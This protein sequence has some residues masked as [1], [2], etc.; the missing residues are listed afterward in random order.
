M[1]KKTLI[2]YFALLLLLCFGVYFSLSLTNN[3][4]YSKVEHALLSSKK[5]KNELE[6][7]L[8][9]FKDD[10]EK[11][12]AAEFLISNMISHYSIGDIKFI[13]NN[14]EEA[15]ELLNITAR[16][17]FFA[18][19]NNVKVKKEIW[20]RNRKAKKEID[21]LINGIRIINNGF[22]AKDI[23]SLSSDFLIEH[24][25]N[26]YKKWKTSKL[27]DKN[28]F[29]EF[30][31]T[32]LP[33]RYANEQLNT[34][35]NYPENICN[36]LL[37]DIIPKDTKEI[38]NTL[39][40]Y[41]LR[42]ERLTS[43]I[44]Q[45]DK[46]GFYNILNWWDLY[47]D[48]QI[49]LAAQILNEIGVP[50]YLDYTP[51]WLNRTLGHSWCVSK[52]S[53]G[54]YRP[55]S[56]FYQ[57]IDS[58]ENKGVYNKNYFKRT[59]K[60]YRKTYE[61]Q[62]QSAIALKKENEVIP[63][64][65]NSQNWKD[66]TDKYH[67]TTS[68]SVPIKGFNY[69]ENNL[70]YLAIFTPRGWIPIDYGLVNQ[71]EKKVSFNKVPKG[72][73]YNVVSFTN[74]KTIPLSAAFYLHDD[75]GIHKIKPNLD[76][77]IKMK[78]LEK[79]PEK[80]RLL[81][82]RIER[83]GSKFQGANNPKFQDAED[84]YEFKEVPKNYVESID[85]KNVKKYRYVRFIA[86][87]RLPCYISVM[88]FYGNKGNSKTPKQESRPYMFNVKDTVNINSGLIKLEGT[89]ISNNQK[90]SFERLNK[91]FDGNTETYATDKWVGIDFEKPKKI[92]VIRYAL[93]SAN[94]R[95]NAGDV[96]KLFY[97]DN[98]WVYFGLQKAKYN[99]LNFK[100][101]PAGTMYWLQ[102]I[103]KGKEELPFMYK[104]G[105]QYFVNHDDLEDII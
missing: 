17:Q 8:A 27:I 94:N 32:F 55:F 81:D 79:Y 31:E 41:F 24:I 74:Q 80:E 42:L 67:K 36:D 18:G 22:I 72:V 102:N 90:A 34:P 3:D 101:V 48:D 4:K 50:T 13:N 14:H 91:A 82:F 9:Y 1:K 69:N 71:K 99:F 49:V 19:L 78:V 23:E 52:D 56:P 54:N 93:R 86:Q 40:G 2:A 45:K 29:N 92:E 63:G 15:L 11:L 60:V 75:G 25:E 26:A 6:K 58:T 57:S 53:L 33:Y 84:L 77:K 97:Y 95:I 61:I 51:I 66:V 44:K 64:F 88:E 85:V 5:N 62:S 83:I 73:V 47:C 38:I 98:G 30:S 87:N 12:K 43:G 35:K 39:N 16:E 104:N 65:F 70:A 59:S 96:Y 10:S 68:I 21:S 20:D 46:L 103:T 89:L 105:K 7:V 37:I 76:K 100:N 28:S